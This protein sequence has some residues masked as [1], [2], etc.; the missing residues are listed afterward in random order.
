MKTLIKTNNKVRD[1]IISIV[2]IFVIVVSLGVSG[3]F[4]YQHLAYDQFWVSGQSMYP[5]LNKEAKYAD[6]TLVGKRR[7]RGFQDGEYDV[8]FGFMTK[9]KKA[10]E[11]ISRF[12]IVVFEAGENLLS[13]NI[14]RIIALPGETFYITSS[15]DEHNGD[16]YILDKSTNEFVYTAQPLESEYITCGSYPETYTTPYTLKD[17]EYFVMGDNREGNNSYD[18]RATGPI[19]KER[20]TGVAVALDGKATLGHNKKGEFT[21][22]KVKRYW[23]RFFK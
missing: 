8:D 5:T 19:S 17:D 21:S 9:S 18:S 3:V 15:K 23:P 10:V 16:L 4:L 7:I 12:N 1:I 20:I 6:G 14:K 2:C 11:K 13:Y 22:V